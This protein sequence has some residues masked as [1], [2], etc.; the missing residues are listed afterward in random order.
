ML[1]WILFEFVPNRPQRG[2]V[3]ANWYPE[4]GRRAYWDYSSAE[5]VIVV[6]NDLLL[7]Q[8][9]DQM[10]RG[11]VV[12]ALTPIEFRLLMYLARH[13]GQ[14]LSLAQI[15]ETVWG[16]ASDIESEK[17]VNVHIR[18]LREKIKL[19]PERFTLILTVPRIGY[20]LAK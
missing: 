12:I 4:F 19:K 15:V 18:R 11:D 16:F 10:R 1:A 6:V 20:R 3:C 8:A 17:T 2:V 5:K 13:R 14:A 7:E 9:T